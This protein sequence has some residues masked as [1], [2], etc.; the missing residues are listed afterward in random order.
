M[1]DH[2]DKPTHEQGKLQKSASTTKN[3]E[4]TPEQLDAIAGGGGYGST[5]VL[6]PPPPRP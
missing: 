3:E 6:P 1:T 4:M 5:S 2:K